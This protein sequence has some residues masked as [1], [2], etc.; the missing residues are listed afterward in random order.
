MQPKA[1]GPSTWQAIHYV[2][3]GYPASFPSQETRDTYRAFYE[4]IG[5][6]LPCPRCAANY[7]THV[8]E[9]PVED[10]LAQGRNALFM[11]TVDLHNT[12]NASLGKRTISHEDAFAMYTRTSA[13]TTG[14]PSANGVRIATLVI[15]SLGVACL[16]VLL[17]RGRMRRG[18]SR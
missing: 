8:A 14:S 3:L 17:Y 18:S 15:S 13:L 12:V 6:V 11:W 9:R 4:V 5:R 16:F 7:A 1:W 2:A 10:A